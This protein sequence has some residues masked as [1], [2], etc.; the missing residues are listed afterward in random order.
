MVQV[1]AAEAW[2]GAASY[3]KELSDHGRLSTVPDKVTTLNRFDVLE[4]SMN[5]LS[6]LSIRGIPELSS[7]FDLPEKS[8]DFLCHCERSA[9]AC[10]RADTHRQVR[11]SHCCCPEGPE[12]AL[13]SPCNDTSEKLSNR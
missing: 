7:E 5:S 4:V 8:S 10:L 13:V 12:I 9:G 3:F 11:Q 2:C 1:P 6:H